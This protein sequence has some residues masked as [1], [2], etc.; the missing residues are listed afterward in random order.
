MPPP[1]PAPGTPR[2]W[3]DRAQG[4]L[5]LIPDPLPPGAYWDDLCFMAQQAAELSIKAVY[6]VHGWFFPYVHDLRVLLDGLE[7]EGLTIPADVREADKISRYAILA[8]YPGF[9]L[10]ATQAEFQDARRIAEAA[11]AWAQSFVP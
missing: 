1:S 7:R 6:Q 2:E 4:K 3:L 5:A 10:P 8:R 9:L 11:V